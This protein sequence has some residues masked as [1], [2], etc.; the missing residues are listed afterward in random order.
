MSWS[1]EE[2][3][4]KLKSQTYVS[5]SSISMAL[6]LALQLDK[7]LLIEGPAGV[8]KTE[9]AKVMAHLLN[10]D[11]IR[12]QCYDGIEVSQALYAWNY[13][14]QLMYLKVQ[15]LREQTDEVGEEA[16]YQDRF[17]L[18]RPI[19]QSITSEQ[20]SVLLID[21]V[22]RSDEA[23]ESFLLEVLSDWQVTIPEIGTLKAKSIPVVILT[24]NATRSLSEALRRRCMYLYIN[25]PDR[26]KEM[27]ILSSRLP[28][29]NGVLIRQVA[30]FMEE[31]RKMK[32]NKVPGVAESLDWGRA[33]AEMYIDELDRNL[34]EDTLGL[35]IKDWKDQREVQLSLSELLDKTGVSSKL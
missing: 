17:L 20:R 15:E 9:V 34:V 25:Y 2:V 19:L 21:E 16:L 22:D 18:K 28:D 33:L 29:L 8:G 24:S 1:L 12:L 31:L 30:I 13:Q 5:D 26:E 3:D 14:Q 10:T 32:L 23:F 27:E 4:Y 35:I 11:L 7:P 6:Y